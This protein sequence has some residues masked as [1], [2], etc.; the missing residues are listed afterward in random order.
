LLSLPP[1]DWRLLNAESGLLQ[2]RNPQSAFRN[3]RRRRLM[4]WQRFAKSPRTA[5]AG[6]SPAASANR[7]TIADCRMQIDFESAIR[8][9]KS[10]I[11]GPVAQRNQSATL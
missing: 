5:R 10:Q 2:I 3:R 7:L 1:I 9:Q 6:S 8:I 11:E 4:V